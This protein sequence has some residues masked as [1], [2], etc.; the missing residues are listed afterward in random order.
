[1][2]PWAIVHPE[3]VVAETREGRVVVT[4]PAEAQ[5]PKAKAKHSA[6]HW[7]AWPCWR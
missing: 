2:L 6:V 4:I 3:M 5:A 7:L 1:M